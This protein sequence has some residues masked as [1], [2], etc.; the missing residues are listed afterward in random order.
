[1]SS[2][3][4]DPIAPPGRRRLFS[5][6]GR[7]P[8]P[9]TK[10][11]R[12]GRHPSRPIGYHRIA[13]CLSPDEGSLR[14]V[15]VACS[16]V[17]ERRAR[18]I[19]IAAIEVPH[20]FALDRPDPQAQAAARNAVHNAQ[21]IAKV[22]GVSVEGV[23][24]HARDPGEAIVA[25]IT[26]HGCDLVVIPSPHRRRRAQTT[27]HILRHAPCRVMLIGSPPADQSVPA[28]TG[29]DPVFPSTHPRTYWPTG[30]FLDHN[31]SA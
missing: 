17:R 26:R 21:S 18:L 29:S 2:G 16:L 31:D 28:N 7:A 12:S 11:P 5:Q 1:M 30:T 4:R 15:H 20:E 24:L 6:R 23:V 14:A 9:T 10:P 22:Y 19:A 25:D 3:R 27:D 8:A 13:V